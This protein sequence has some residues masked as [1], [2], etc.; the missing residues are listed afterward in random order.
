MRE[1]TEADYLIGVGPSGVG[2]G[3]R[4]PHVAQVLAERPDVAW[5]EALADNYLDDLPGSEPSRALRG[6]EA[7]RAHYPVVLHSVGL[8]L[9]STD[10]LDEGY[11]ARLRALVERVEPAAVSD[12]FAWVS[13]GG[14][15]VH[16]LLPLP[17]T[18]EVIDHVAPRIALVQDALGRRLLIENPSRYLTFANDEL[19]LAEVLAELVRRTGCGLL[20]DVTNAYVSEV[21]VNTSA[22]A[23]I[24]ALPAEAIGY[25]H[26]AGPTQQPDHLLDSHDAPVPEE[27]WRLYAH[28]VRRL[29][30]APTLIEWDQDLP[31]FE[32]LLAQARRA[33][34]VT[35]E[36]LA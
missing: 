18:E 21:N 27:V 22:T 32:T 36:A 20:L 34:E 31:A 26:L 19:A 25:I 29:G 9:G 35:A 30:P 6:L 1:T 10:P 11:V 5:F 33:R 2:L 3:L 15:H 28:A 12:H 23:F 14:V 7:V 13:V 24:D 17:C 16:D 8:S 4:Q